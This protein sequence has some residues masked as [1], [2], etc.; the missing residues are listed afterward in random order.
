GTEGALAISD[1]TTSAI[2]KLGASLGTSASSRMNGSVLV[3]ATSNTTSNSTMASTIVGT[4]ALIGARQAFMVSRPSL[5][6]LMSQQ[7]IS[8]MPVN[9]NFKAAGALSLA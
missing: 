4:P 5:T 8:L 2:A 6:S 7:M 3:E 1:I 9:F